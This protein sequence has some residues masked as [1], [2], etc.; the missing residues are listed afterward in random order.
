MKL[1]KLLQTFQNRPTFSILD[2]EKHFTHFD[3]E[4]L[5]H[6]QEKG[7]IQRIR[8]G[9]Y[10]VKQ[11]L[12]SI[13]DLYFI[14]NKIYAPSYIS[15]ESA[16]AHYG[17]IP[18]GVFSI[19]SLSTKKTMDFQTPLGLFQYQKIK[20]SLFFGYRLLQTPSGF[21]VKLAEPEKAALDY[22]YFHPEL[23]T[24]EDFVA[25][26]WNTWKLK[27]DLNEEVLKDYATLFDSAMLNKRLK[28]FQEFMAYAETI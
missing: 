12:Q 28:I 27:E 16:F 3:R 14:A 21:G 19:R 11:D 15:L 9:W 25:L 22:L 23:Q 24:I 1:L 4:N 18:E 20:A 2:I 13:L 26:R 10:R 8:N 17:W 5:L 7:Y 6:W